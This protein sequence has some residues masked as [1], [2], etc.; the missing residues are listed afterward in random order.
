MTPSITFDEKAT[1][2]FRLET[3]EGSGPYNTPETGI[4]TPYAGFNHPLAEDEGCMYNSCDI[5]GFANLKSLHQWFSKPLM[6][7]NTD[8]FKWGIGVYAIEDD[9]FIVTPTQMVFCSYSSEQIGWAA[10]NEVN[11]HALYEHQLFVDA[12][13]DTS[14]TLASVTSGLVSDLE[15][16]MTPLQVH[17]RARF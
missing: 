6:D 5:F 9:D 11:P 15:S 14:L 10:L 12:S 17:A 3:E 13:Q 16:Q 7:E 4:Y 1:V 8:V 2:A